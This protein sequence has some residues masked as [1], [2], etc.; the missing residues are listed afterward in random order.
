MRSH[1]S[2]KKVPTLK[3]QKIPL[4]KIICRIK[5]IIRLFLICTHIYNTKLDYSHEEAIIWDFYSTYE[6]S[7]LFLLVDPEVGNQWKERI[8]EELG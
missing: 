4:S 5:K 1:L 6:F 7:I 3:A 8:R 2:Q